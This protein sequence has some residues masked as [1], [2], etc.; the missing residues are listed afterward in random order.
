MGVSEGQLWKE[1][2]AICHMPTHRSQK[3]ALPLTPIP[4]HGR[5]MNIKAVGLWQS[6]LALG[7]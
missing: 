2:S 4:H 6:Q 1:A 7:G 3:R 5:P